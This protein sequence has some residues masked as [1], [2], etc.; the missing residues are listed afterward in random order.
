MIK[1]LIWYWTFVDLYMK[2]LLKYVGVYITA[3]IFFQT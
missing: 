3:I 1:P 2:S